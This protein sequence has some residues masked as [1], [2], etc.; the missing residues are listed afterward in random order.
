MRTIGLSCF[1]PSS[2]TASTTANSGRRT[3]AEAQVRFLT[4][5]AR[6][7]R[8]GSSGSNWRVR[9]ELR[10]GLTTADWPGEQRASQM[11]GK[12]AYERHLAR[13]RSARQS[14]HSITSTNSLHRPKQTKQTYANRNARVCASAIFRI[15]GVG[16]KPWSTGERCAPGK[17]RVPTRRP[18]YAWPTLSRPSGNSRTCLPVALKRALATAGATGGTPGSPTPVG[19][20]VGETIWTSTFGMSLMRS[21][22]YVSKFAWSTTPPVNVIASLRGLSH[23]HGGEPEASAAQGLSG[24]CDGAPP[25]VHRHSAKRAVRSG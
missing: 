24:C 12:R 20:S 10:N 14:R 9:S 18:L 23:C 2:S 25:C 7:Y 8:K 6:S 4:L 22:S 1:R 5:R 19:C 17:L 13:D 11:G 15:S 21:G 3:R 16:E